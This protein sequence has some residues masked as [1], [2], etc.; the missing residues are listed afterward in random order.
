MAIKVS[1]TTVINDSRALQNIASLDATTTA[2]IN[3]VVGSS[4]L[5]AA[6]GGT[7]TTDGDFKVHKFTSDG[8]FTITAAGG[9][10]SV[11][12]VSGGGRGGRG[13]T[14]GRSGGG[15]GAGG[16]AEFSF[17]T[18]S[19]GAYTVV[20]GA[21]SPVTGDETGSQLIRGNPSGIL[22][23]DFYQTGMVGG[24]GAGGRGTEPST[25]DSGGGGA[26]GGGRNIGALGNPFFGNNGGDVP[27]PYDAG[28]G[29]GGAGGVGETT[30]V[31]GANGG[32]GGIGIASSITGTSTYY[33][34]GGG[35]GGGNGGSIGV[36]GN[37]GGG[38]GG[39]YGVVGSNGTAN[40]GGG[41][42]GGGGYGFGGAGGSGVVIL[43]YKFQ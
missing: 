29:G 5:V 6:T 35:A 16:A 7:I 1:G 27:S 13:A 38:G 40:T 28:A 20:V 26:E 9:S 17:Q 11:L 36:G 30:S 23:P 3:A 33:G 32:N 25:G 24:G 12:I 2:T 39:N 31:S 15:G 22:G 18:F 10:C 41:G 42:G 14:S 4:D 19:T 8:T 37:G 21:G 34:G 43:R